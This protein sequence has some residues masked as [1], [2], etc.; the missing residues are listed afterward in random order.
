MA[1]ARFLASKWESWLPVCGLLLALSTV[2]LFAGNGYFYGN[3]AH[4]DFTAKHMAIAGNLGEPGGSLFLTKRLRPLGSVRYD[5]YNRFPIGSFLLTRLVTA[6]F[7]GDFSAQLTSARALALMFYFAAA[8]LAYLA[9]AQLTGSRAVALGATLVAFSSYHA[10]YYSDIVFNESPFD[11]FA[12]ML[13][14]HGMVLAGGS[15]RRFGQLAIKTCVALLLGWHVYGLLLPFVVLGGAST[16][17]SAWRASASKSFAR[18]LGAAA[19]AASRGRVALLGALA[20]LFGVGV[21]GFNF[22][23]EYAAFD[24][25]WAVENLP[26]VRS[27]L[28]RTGISSVRQQLSPT[29]PE[30][31][32]TGQSTAGFLIQHFHRIGALCVPFALRG[33]L[34]M[35]EFA[36]RDESMPHPVF[37]P[38]SPWLW[39]TGICATLGALAGLVLFR[40][41]RSPPAA[42]ALAGIG[43]AVL[44]TNQ[45]IHSG[46]QFETLFN[47]GVPLCLF[48]AILVGVRRLFGRS[49]AVAGAAAAMAI[50]ALSSVAMTER[51][52]DDDEARKQRQA[53][54]EFDPVAETI[55][56]QTVWVDA[57]DRDFF[58]TFGI[59]ESFTARDRERKPTTMPGRIYFIEFFTTGSF[60]Y[61]RSPLASTIEESGEPDFILTFARYQIPTLLTPAHQHVFLYQGGARSDA[62]VEAMA[63]ALAQEA[64]RLGHSRPAVRGAF[65]VSLLQGGKLYY[66]RSSCRREDAQR[67]FFLHVAPHVPSVLSKE[68]RVHG[69]DNFDFDFNQYGYRRAD[70]SCLAMI[71]L[72]DYRIARVRT[73]QSDRDGGV[74]WSVEFTPESA[75]ADSR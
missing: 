74:T 68:R 38:T 8:L 14:F 23:R 72:P 19:L 36:W 64:R 13:V 1:T 57:Y 58:S 34:D 33:G 22:A 40:G 54:A 75:I 71:S 42:L 15:K 62:L 7:D 21:L 17:A 25:R 12:V 3:R 41:P 2:W 45:T 73:G 37:R 39:L 24:G 28:H 60:V 5:T 11:L 48:A 32:N 59:R 51:N 4:D 27:A 49:A 61:Y 52:L 69:F 31:T 67:P 20:L 47:V 29:S 35:D 16:A 63:D 44:A 46:H 30:S 18:R 43:W 70:G 26:S 55:R 56:G 6:P 65:D 10:L 9:L 66:F 53:M 50:F